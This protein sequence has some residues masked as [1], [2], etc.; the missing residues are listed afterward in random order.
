MSD[1]ITKS[2]KRLMKQSPNS[3]IEQAFGGSVENAKNNNDIVA[4][5][6]MKRA[7]KGEVSAIK[8]MRDMLKSDSGGKQSTSKLYDAL[9]SE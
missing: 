2:L 1:D 5:A 3:D 7:A 6:L 8:E 9:K 4:A